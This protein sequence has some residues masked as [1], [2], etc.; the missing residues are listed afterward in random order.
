[1]VII[2]KIHMQPSH[3]GKEN[4]RLEKRQQKSNVVF[5]SPMVTAQF[6]FK[7]TQITF[8]HILYCIMFL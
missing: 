8:G 4:G 2:F 6:F 1:M 3:P 5:E 7:L